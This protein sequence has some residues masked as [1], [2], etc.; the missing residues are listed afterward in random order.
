MAE[1][2]NPDASTK[3]DTTDDP[4]ITEKAGAAASDAKAKVSDAANQAK[5]KLSQAGD[6]V[7]SAAS[8]AKARYEGVRDK[9]R[10]T[11]Y[12]AMTTDL[13]SY[14][15]E[16]PGKAIVVAAAAGFLIGLLLRDS[17]D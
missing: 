16:N 15:R 7:R 8:Q 2:K 17:E 10:E 6:S 12:G 9:V 13:K 5:R 14:V 11:D 3:V 4:G 1:V